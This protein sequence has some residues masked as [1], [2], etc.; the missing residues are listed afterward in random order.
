[1]NTHIG[2]FA[3]WKSLR[4]EFGFDLG[5]GTTSNFFLMKITGKE[6]LSLY[7]S[8]S[9]S[10]LLA[11]SLSFPEFFSLAAAAAAVVVIVEEI[12]YF[13]CCVTA[14]VSEE[15]KKVDNRGGY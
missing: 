7:L 4:E 11:R 13:G 2:H 12:A 8:L 3:V 14:N 6:T 10:G 1:M 5:Y 9:L 15:E